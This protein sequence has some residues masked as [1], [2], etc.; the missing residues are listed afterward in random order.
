[1]RMMMI[2]IDPLRILGMMMTKI[3][4]LMRKKVLKMMTIR[5]ST[6]RHQI[7]IMMKSNFLLSLTMMS[8]LRLFCGYYNTNNDLNFQMSQ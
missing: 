4:I 8:V 2:K 3:S 6:L 1:M 5:R 7:S